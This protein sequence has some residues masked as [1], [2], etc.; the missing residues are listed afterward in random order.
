MDL[1]NFEDFEDISQEESPEKTLSPET[2][3]KIENITVILDG[4]IYVNPVQ[5]ASLEKRKTKFEVLFSEIPLRQGDFLSKR[6]FDKILAAAAIRLSQGA[7]YGNVKFEYAL[8]EKGP[9]AENL[10]PITLYVSVEQS[11]PFLYF[12]GNAYA[13]LGYK[14]P[15]GVVSKYYAGANRVEAIFDKKSILFQREDGT[16][17]RTPLIA[18]GRAFGYWNYLSPWS[19]TF[20]YGGS[21]K[22]GLRPI[23]D[24]HLT[25]EAQAVGASTY[26]EKIPT[27]DIESMG[28]PP[29]D[30][31]GLSFGGILRLNH[32]WAF[33]QGGA[34]TDPILNSP[35]PSAWGIGQ[36]IWEKNPLNFYD[37]YGFLGSMQ[38]AY[39]LFLDQALTLRGRLYH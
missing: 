12:G 4:E 38:F 20:L 10:R 21:A 35:S 36:A 29:A 26:E 1:D 28:L 15:N 22:I 16:F 5:N 3:I 30:S 2:I 6:R 8:D 33:R 9:S 34:I 39:S 27:E 14:M 7:Y 24:L 31:T 17:S 13:S 23:P 25:L 37:S 32:Q 18:G 11:H 19:R